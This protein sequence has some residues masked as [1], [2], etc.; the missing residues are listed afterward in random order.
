MLLRRK[1]ARVYV[2]KLPAQA[3]CSM[4]VEKQPVLAREHG[5]N[6]ITIH[7]TTL[8]SKFRKNDIMNSAELQPSTNIAPQTRHSR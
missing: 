2:L 7:I 5:V 3:A 6:I 1:R 4:R 8:L